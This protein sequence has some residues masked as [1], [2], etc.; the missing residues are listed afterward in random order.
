[1]FNVYHHISKSSATEVGI[2]SRSRTR[3]REGS[4]AWKRSNSLL[5]FF[6][7]KAVMP[8]SPSNG[9]SRRISMRFI[10]PWNRGTWH[11]ASNHGS[12]RT[13]KFYPSL[14]EARD[15]ASNHGSRRTAKFYPSLK[16]R[17][18]TVQATMG[19][20]E[21]L[22]FILPWNR[23]TWQCKQPWEQKNR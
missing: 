6:F 16:Q 3:G 13:A 1:M 8:R 19:A 11:G 2:S 20:E 17:H 21:P 15:S 9:G 23:G 14:T 22:S 18:V 4:R 7:E 12:R 10:L 5:D